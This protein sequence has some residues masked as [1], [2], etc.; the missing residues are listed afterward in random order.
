M[1]TDTIDNAHLLAADVKHFEPSE[2]QLKLDR[3]W[4]RAEA[5][6]TIGKFAMVI[7]EVIYHKLDEKHIYW[8]NQKT[9]KERKQIITGY[10]RSKQKEIDDRITASSR[11]TLEN[12][13]EAEAFLLG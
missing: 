9:G 3:L 5:I 11:R 13:Q 10:S 8:C 6:K 2:R 7:D 1:D 4:L 12:M